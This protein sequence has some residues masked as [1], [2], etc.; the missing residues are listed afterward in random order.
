MAVGGVAQDRHGAGH[1]GTAR[2]VFH[3]HAHLGEGL[4]QLAGHQATH[5]VHGT[6]WRVGHHH[7]DGA[8]RPISLGM[9]HV[10]AQHGCQTGGDGQAQNLT[11]DMLH[12]CLLWIGVDL[13][14]GTTGRSIGMHLD[15][16]LIYI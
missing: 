7:L 1:G 15:T 4:A 10:Q 2:N 16:R 5:D 11:A 14:L 3:Y 8:A 13:L 12:F 6:S 9:G